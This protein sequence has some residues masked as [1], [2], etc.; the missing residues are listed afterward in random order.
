MNS[1]SFASR[2]VT[3]MLAGLIALASMVVVFA[4]SGTGAAHE[5]HG[6]A[7]G[8]HGHGDGATPRTPKQVAFHDSMRALWEAH[9]AWTHMVIT[10]FVGSLPNLPAEEEVL[11]QNQVDIGD[12]VK[13]YY[14][15]AAGDELTKL[16]KEH[17]LGAVDVLVAAKSGDQDKLA[18]AEDAWYANGRE[19]AD[20]LHAANPRF[21]GRKAA[22]EMMKE[23]LDQVIEQAVDELSGDYAGSARAY[24]PYI[25]HILDMAD[26]ISGGIIKQF[27]ARFR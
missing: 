27:P 17:I 12:A 21:L 3:F 4:I 23:H 15:N 2:R 13:P 9:G 20:F 25:S 19:I 10:S 5:H 24:G 26:M 11:L 8:T 16:L 1:N 18:Q 14:G 7:H 6:A 22:R